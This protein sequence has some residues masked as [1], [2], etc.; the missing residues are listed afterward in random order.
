MMQPGEIDSI[1][2]LGL[3]ISL[4]PEAIKG[5]LT[6]RLPFIGKG[7]KL[8]G[9]GVCLHWPFGVPVAMRFRLANSC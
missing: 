7:G 6:G 1:W 8:A 3:L 4:D 9:T 2:R 5:S